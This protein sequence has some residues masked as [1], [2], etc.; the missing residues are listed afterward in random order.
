TSFDVIEHIPDLDS[1]RRSIYSLLKPGGIFVFVVPVYDGPLGWVV[2][3]LDKDPTHIHKTRRTFW[4]DWAAASFEVL[5]WQGA[6]RY[7]TPFGVYL[8]YPSRIL[9][10][11]SP[12]IAVVARRR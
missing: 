7:M 5:E 12:A 2:H 6:F 1:T 10:R 8:H 9:R 11:G 4:L 3:A